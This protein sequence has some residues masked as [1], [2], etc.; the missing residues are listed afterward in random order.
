[1]RL[2]WPLL[3]GRVTLG[4]GLDGDVESEESISENCERT[5]VEQTTEKETGENRE[6]ERERRKFW[7]KAD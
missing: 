4:F 1:L 6:R 7:N 5:I 3:G 2:I